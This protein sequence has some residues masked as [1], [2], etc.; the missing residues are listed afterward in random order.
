M[1]YVPNTLTVARILLTPFFLMLLVSEAPGSRHLALVLFILAAFSDWLDGRL[2]RAYEARS[3]LGKFL[4]PLADKILV[5]GTFLVLPILLPRVIPWWAV[6]AIAARD[7][8]VT[9]LRTWAESHQQSVPTLRLARVK[10]FSQ[11]LF[12]VGILAL[13]VVRDVPG[14]AAWAETILYGPVTYIALLVVVGMT[15]YTG[16]LYIGYLRYRTPWAI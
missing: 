11:L 9:G 4:D 8:I 2:A 3:R 12:L 15:L 1:K 6:I 16:L 10:T 7:I 5:L 14:Y 13:V